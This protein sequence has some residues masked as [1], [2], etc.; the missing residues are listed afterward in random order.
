VA[1][2]KAFFFAKKN[3]KTLARLSRTNRRQKRQSF[4]FFFKKKRFLR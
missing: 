1:E 2:G 3:Q 4:C